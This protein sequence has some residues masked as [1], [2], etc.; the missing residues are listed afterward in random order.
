MDFTGK[1]MKGW[2]YVSEAGV[3]S[4]EGLAALTVYTQNKT[5]EMVRDDILGALPK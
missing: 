5:P 1:P 4:D 2:V 3:A